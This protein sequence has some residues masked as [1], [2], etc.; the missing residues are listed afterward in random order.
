[1]LPFYQASSAPTPRVSAATS[2][3]TLPLLLRK[4]NMTILAMHPPLPR[5][6]P[7]LQL[8]RATLERTRLWAWVLWWALRRSL[9]EHC[10]RKHAEQNEMMMDDYRRYYVHKENPRRHSIYRQQLC[11]T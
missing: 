9:W 3:P 8:Q 11:A 4:V 2:S 5:P 10:L 7:M 6:V 1:M